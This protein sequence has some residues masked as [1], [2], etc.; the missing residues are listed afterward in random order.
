MLKR[1][2][3]IRAEWVGDD[4]DYPQYLANGSVYV[5]VSQEARP[6]SGFFLADGS[7]HELPPSEPR[8]WGF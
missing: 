8:K 6:A 5:L 3:P 4:T 1:L 2:I 7:W